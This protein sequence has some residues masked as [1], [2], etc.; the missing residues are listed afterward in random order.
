MLQIKARIE[1]FF[2]PPN[3]NQMVALQERTKQESVVQRFIKQREQQYR[4]IRISVDNERLVV[5][6][7]CNA[8]EAEVTREELW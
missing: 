4:A 3:K 1:H 6:H 2:L 8:K 5:K 7:K